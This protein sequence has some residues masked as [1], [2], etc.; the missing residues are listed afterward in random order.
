MPENSQGTQ[1]FKTI[2]LSIVCIGA[3]AWGLD[4]RQVVFRALESNPELQLLRI[5]SQDDSLTL[6]AAKA[7]WLPSASFSLQ[8]SITPVD[9][10]NV[11]IA[12][13]LY[14]SLTGL[15]TITGYNDTGYAQPSSQVTA[16]ITVAQPVPGGGTV[17]AGLSGDLQRPLRA[18]S[19]THNA[20]Y[21]LLFSQPLLKG[22]WR[23]GT[24]DYQ[25]RIA[26]LRDVEF[27]LKRKKSLITRVSSVRGR[28]WTFYETS[29][30]V[31]IAQN[32]LDRSTEQLQTERQRLKIGESSPLDTLNAALQYMRAQEKV[33]TAGTALNEARNALATALM[34]PKD[35][36]SIPADIS[37]TIP[38]LPDPQTFVALVERFDPQLAIFERMNVLLR[39][40]LEK[41]R[42][43]MLPALDLGAGISGRAGGNTLRAIA[44]TNFNA[45]ISLVL[46]YDLPLRPRTIAI[47][48]QHLDQERND[49]S[50]A[51]YHRELLARLDELRTTWQQ[52]KHRLSIAAASVELARRQLEATQKGYD[53]GTEDR[54]S[55]LSARDDLIV[56]ENG[57][58]SA[59]I[60]MKRLEIVLDEITGSAIER[61]GLTF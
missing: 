55:L 32:E 51:S 53:L 2:T 48:K 17:S 45:V 47:R 23:N 19:T 61:F 4:E 52:E 3:F 54:L 59:Q 35:S 26:R 14:D 40:Q 25:V 27:S 49:I 20:S 38:D 58:L 15:R 29:S 31:A 28:F 39:E 13:T 41:E 8:P 24:I 43:S 22:A 42:N 34:I 21:S 16:G 44:S 36:L 33:L 9:T 30:R 7:G 18:D 37:I 1:M 50:A 6:E 56:A 60:G 5:D 10:S 11:E 57:F 46:R 12:R